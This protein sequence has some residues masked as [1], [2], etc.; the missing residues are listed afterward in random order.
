MV[1]EFLYLNAG[2]PP[3][4]DPKVREAI[5]LSINRQNFVDKVW[6]GIGVPGFIVDPEAYPDLALPASQVNQYPGIRQPKDQ[7]IARAKELLKE[8]GFPTGVDIGACRTSTTGTNPDANAV[9]VA[10]LAKSGIKC[11]PAVEPFAAMGPKISARNYGTYNQAGGGRV[12]H[13][14]DLFVGIY[15]K[16]ATD[17]SLDYEDPV[18]E[19]LYLQMQRTLDPAEEKRIVIALQRHIYETRTHPMVPINW[20]RYPDITRSYVRDHVLGVMPF[21]NQ[22]WD[23]TWFDK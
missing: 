22:L 2:V 4:N 9:T 7:D 16:I 15:A 18:V 8:A 10:D 1:G 23:F 14:I 12:Y 17:V 21:E 19:D 13:P 6:G 20:R 5:Y 3:L 11:T